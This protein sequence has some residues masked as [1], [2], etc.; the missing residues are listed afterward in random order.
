M[1]QESFQDGAWREQNLGQTEVQTDPLI[2]QKIMTK[3]DQPLVGPQ[4]NSI[5]KAKSSGRTSW[6]KRSIS[7]ELLICGWVKTY[8][9][10]A[11]FRG[12]M[13]I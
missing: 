5:H 8:I 6:Q 7:Y 4:G 11:T 10:S 1:I 9:A 3:H 12:R 13:G 2:P